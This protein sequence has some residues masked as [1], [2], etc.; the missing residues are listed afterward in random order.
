MAHAGT[1]FGSTGNPDLRGLP[2]RGVGIRTFGFR[3]FAIFGHPVAFYI[4]ESFWRAEIPLW[5]PLNNCGIPFLAQWNTLALYPGSLFL[6]ILPLPWSLGIFCL[7][8]AGL[9]GLGMY[10][11]VRRWAGTRLGAAL[12]GIAFVFNGTTLNCLMWPGLTATLAWMPWTVLCV[13]R[14]WRAG[15]RAWAAA[16]VTGTMQMLTG[17]PELIALTWLLIGALAT[18]DHARHES[19][20][21]QR[22]GKLVVIILLVTG[23]SAAQLLPF[24]ELLHNSDRDYGFANST[25]SMPPTGWANLLVPLFR[26]YQSIQEVYLQLEQ[27]WTSSYYLGIGVLA[28]AL[29]ACWQVRRRRVRLLAAVVGVTLVLSLGDNGHLYTWLRYLVPQVSFMRYPMKFHLLTTFCVP[30]LAAYAVNSITQSGSDKWRDSCRSGL[31]LTAA[32]LILIAGILCFDYYYPAS[33]ELHAAWSGGLKNGAGRAVFLLLIIGSTCLLRK[34]RDNERLGPLLGVAILSLVAGDVLTHAPRQNPTLPVKALKPG[35]VRLSPRPQLGMSR[36]MMAT[37]AAVAHFQEAGLS[38]L[39]IY[40]VQRLGLMENCNLLEDI[41]KVDGFY[42]LYLQKPQ[43]VIRSRWKNVNPQYSPIWD[44][45][46]TSFTTSP[47]NGVIWEPRPNYMAWVSAGQ[48]PVFPSEETAF[49]IIT[50]TNFNP[51]EI[52]CLPERLRNLL[53]IDSPTRASVLRARFWPHR[54]EIDLEADK[55]SLAVIAQSYYPCWKAQVDGNTVPLW[56][57][58]YGFQAVPVPSGQHTVRLAYEDQQFRRGSVI[59]VA[60]LLFCVLG[61][62][63]SHVRRSL[64]KSNA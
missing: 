4:R 14:A 10:H 47:T 22:A 31:I 39:D 30:V 43:E 56:R 45:L 18:I 49:R 42:G 64:S 50:D 61:L 21:L 1:F 24:F 46:G 35:L 15:R 19:T 55:P 7:A 63:I 38:L 48:M 20:M 29:T 58:N 25:W 8:H 54:V 9:G 17:T 11:L 16:V 32:F 23:L 52:V 13:E 5:N 27:N 40:V 44:F 62:T 28:L 2:G 53:R 57:A 60:A 59:S 33:V 41:P 6:L 36:A 3:D 37:K 34:L 26:S 51:R 12:A